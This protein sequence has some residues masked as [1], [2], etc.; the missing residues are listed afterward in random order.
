MPRSPN[1]TG[2]Q[3]L[4]NGL[5]WKMRSVDDGAASENY[6]ALLQ[7]WSCLSLRPWSALGRLHALLS[8]KPIP[9]RSVV[10]LTNTL[11][12]RPT[13]LSLLRVRVPAEVWLAAGVDPVLPTIGWGHQFGENTLP[14]GADSCADNLEETGIA[15]DQSPD[16]QRECRW[17][18]KQQKYRR[19]FLRLS[20]SETPGLRVRVTC[21]RRCGPR[22]LRLR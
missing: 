14:K 16:A 17:A 13:S 1:T 11:R 7:C 18:A 20:N 3:T 4:H 2:E 19:Y 10:R 9:R 8:R 5:K 21:L 12:R 15:R 6:W 22:E